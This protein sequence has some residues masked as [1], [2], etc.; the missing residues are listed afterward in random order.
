MVDSAIKDEEEKKE[1]FDND[2][3]L[4]LKTDTLVQWIKESKHFVAFTGAGIS[5]AAGVADFRSGVNTVLE[6][7]PGVWEKGAQK[8]TNFEPKLKVEMAKAYPTKCHMS[9]VKLMQQGL[10]KFLISQNV[11]G[12]HRKS[13]IPPEKIAE[14]H[15]NTNLEVCSKC[16]KGYMRDYRTR[17]AKTV[18]NHMTGRICEI[19]DCKGKLKDSIINFGENLPEKDL[20]LGFAQSQ[21]ADLHVCLGSS[22]RVTPAADMPVET[23]NNGGKL[24]IIK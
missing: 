3:E 4:E 10:L 18:H 12:L 23:I 13:G 7:G 11:D 21:L 1:F 14:L 16:G 17:T 8:L 15:G 20:E 19:P 6:T 5:T 22:L 24:V 2:E 9:L